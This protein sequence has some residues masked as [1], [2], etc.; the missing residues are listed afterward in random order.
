MV[1]TSKN[2]FCLKQ[3]K[4]NGFVGKISANTYNGKVKNIFEICVFVNMNY[5]Y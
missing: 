5:L 3:Q 2:Y 4:K 1:V